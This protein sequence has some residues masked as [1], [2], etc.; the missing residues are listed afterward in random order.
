MRRLM[1][2]SLLTLA[3]L[4]LPACAHN[5]AR[6]ELPRTAQGQVRGTIEGD[7]GVYR[8][9][10]YA[11]PPSG[12]LRWKP[13]QPAAPWQGVR[14]ATAFGPSCPQGVIPGAGARE[15]NA[16]RGATSEDCLTL[17]IWAPARHAGPLPVMVWIHGGAHRIGSGS[18]PFY[19][20]SAFARDGVILVTF[21]Y[22][23][24]LLGYLA[25]PAL[26]AEAAADAPLANYGTMD[27]L[28]ALRWVQA[29]IAAFG[30]DPGNVTL[31]GE[32]AGGVATLSLLT[33]PEARGLFH[34]AIVESGGGWNATPDLAEAERNG[35]AALESAGVRPGAS[36]A[37][38]RALPPEAF[39][40]FK[41]GVGFGPVID[42]RLLKQST[43]QA[44]AAGDVVD[45]PLIIGFN[46]DEGSLMESFQMAPST[47][48]GSVPGAGLAAL[49]AAY[50]A[51]G[52]TDEALARRLFADGAFSAPAR[53][54]AGRSA[55]GAPSWLYRFDYVAELLRGQ[56]SGARHGG[57]IPFVFDSWSAMPAIAQALTEDDRRMAATIHGCWVSFAK[58]GVP[59]CPGAPAWP[60]YAP[61]SD[62]LLDFAAV[63][64][65]RTGFDKPI[66]DVLERTLLPR[67]LGAAPRR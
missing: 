61:A 65:P 28:A 26:T 7:V 32:S 40:G 54:I 55:G 41:A 60:A 67:A 48:L 16:V 5:Q 52:A 38:L 8:G 66:Y 2:I 3:G 14:D 25:H 23:L 6:P 44:F 19:D 42:G 43:A 33:L 21:N 18:A 49:R 59:V 46:S 35:A 27:Q 47:M 45:V 12:A 13:P 24:G 63:T 15:A 29:N 62:T 57:E 53:W 30:G 51:R 10:P 34:K 22:R 20:G 36:L 37:E 64:A 4:L 56:R 9:I 11:A 39:A 1:T 17:N 31:F 50:G 58:T